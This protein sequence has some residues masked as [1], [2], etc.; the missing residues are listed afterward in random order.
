MSKHTVRLTGCRPTPLALYLKALGVFRIVAEQA[1]ADARGWWEDS[2]FCLQSRLDENS[3]LEFL[4]DEYRPA[5]IVAPWNGGSGFNPKDNTS[6]IEAIAESGTERFRPYREAIEACRSIRNRL[7]LAEKPDG[8]EKESL[9]VECRSSLPD[10]VLSWLDA[11]MVLTEDGPKYPPLLG[12]GGNDGRL[13]F[14]NNFM[15]RLCELLVVDGDGSIEHS[16]AVLRESLYQ[17]P[18]PGLLR[19]SPIGQFHPGNAG[20]SNSGTGFSADAA[21]N[22]WDFVLVLEGALLFASFVT[23]KIGRTA[24]GALSYPFSVRQSAVGYESSSSSDEK[25]ARAEI[26]MPLWPRAANLT[27][28][29]TL[30]SEGRAEV[31]GRPARHGVDFARAVASLG[32]A[33]GIAGFERFGFQVR[34]GLS[35]FA[36]PL[37]RFEVSQNSQEEYIRE[38]D[39]WLDAYRRA[40]T[41]DTAPATAVRALHGL[42]S[43]VMEL[44]RDKTHPERLLDMVLALGEAEHVLVVSSKWRTDNYLHPV[45]CL[46][47]RW[48]QELE[49]HCSKSVEFRLAASLAGVFEE[50][51]FRQHLGPIVRPRLNSDPRRWFSDKPEHLQ[52]VEWTDGSLVNNL[53]AVLLRRLLHTEQEGNSDNG[54]TKGNRLGTRSSRT[55]SMGDIGRFI[56][57]TVDEA[58]FTGMLRG[59]ALL[60]IPKRDNSSKSVH[61]NA[62]FDDNAIPGADYALLKLCYMPYPVRDTTVPVEPTIA[63]LA[64]SGDMARATRLAARRLRGSG[65][66]SAVMEVEGSPE[67]AKRIAASLLFPVSSEQG[68]RMANYVL[69]QPEQE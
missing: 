62:T 54:Q 45:P 31:A 33:R 52:L 5:P 30:F 26:W 9:I 67:R 37:G 32:V 66:A 63:R 15:Q 25:E 28:L 24:K 20:G 40:A 4:L 57:G 19:K 56:D 7:G 50:P 65:L 23:K 61:D 22:A 39:A 44:C 59:L 47:A 64:I 46:S 13:D 35:Y 27:E 12:T 69:D 21:I 58:K 53:C 6:A 2:V 29:K 36:V 41:K 34:N 48:F 42:E 1:D 38:I 51:T 18:A 8:T 17:D 55:A 16:R 14:S 68:E 3:L 49:K 11:A 43:S 60:T 10:H